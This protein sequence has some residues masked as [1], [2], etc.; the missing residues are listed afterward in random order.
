MVVRAYLRRKQYVVKCSCGHTQEIGSYA[1]AQLAMG[2][3]L[4]GKC[5]KCGKKQ[6]LMGYSKGDKK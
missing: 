3:T 1:V 2:Y 4:S 6:D 5:Q